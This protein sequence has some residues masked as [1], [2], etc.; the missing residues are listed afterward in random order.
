MLKS[1]NYK[2]NILSIVVNTI[3]WIIVFCV[4]LINFY[5]AG[6]IFAYEDNHDHHLAFFSF[7]GGMAANGIFPGI[8]FYSP[9]SVFIPLVIGIFFKFLGI[10]QVSLGISDGVIVFI[11]M[12]F[13][14]KCARLVMPSMF[15]KLAVLTILLSHSGKDNPWFNDVIMLF[16]AI[17]IYY[18]AL[19]FSSSKTFV[20]KTSLIIVGIIAFL[21]PYMRQQGLVIS[22]C[23]LL[24]PVIL[25]Y[26]KQLKLLEYKMMLSCIVYTFL[27]S[28]FLFLVF[29]VIKN[30]FLG[31]E[32]LY[33]SFGELVDMAQPAIGYENSISSV[34]NSLFNYT[35]DGMDWHGYSMKFL[36]Y[37]FIVILPCLY[38]LYQPFKKGY[39]E[40][41]TITKED[42]IRFIASLIVLSTIIFNY[43]INEDARMRVQ[44]GVGIWLFVESLRLCF[45]H[46]NIKFI[47]F[48]AIALVF[49]LIHHSKI[50]Q[51]V[52]KV[53]I[54]YVNMFQ[55][56]DSY[57]KM[58]D[59]SP[60]KNMVFKDDYAL[61]IHSLL[62]SIE[63]YYTKNPNTKIIFNGE[64][65][66]INNY[67]FLLFSGPEVDIAHKFPY[68]YGVFNREMIF[69][70]INN[71]FNKYIN[72]N[73]PMIID[74]E[75]KKDSLPSG[76]K[77]LDEI[78]NSC[79]ILIP[80]D[81]D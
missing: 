81:K 32:I 65:I 73:K 60:Y 20:K 35:A 13:I 41:S 47:S 8:D 28:N 30:V 21:L 79:N 64:L 5:A 36:S 62:S 78:N 27:I 10:S 49:L 14:Y 40:E 33:T 11:T 46:K 56:K 6:S 26:T 45:Y 31:I 50:V 55:V 9:H 59:N 23:F 54:N 18:F 72:E 25:F 17:G 67:L 63:D 77:I 57:Q 66:N 80:Y 12:I 74:C 4:V 38:F 1:K 76:Y 34:A 52:N 58:P 69:P 75:F 39:G 43:P 51:F 22:F 7:L 3:F 24:L 29:V 71:E 37:W 15:A 48:I 19:Y 44:F 16:V 2:K 42:S 68:Y 53:E 70:E 61:H